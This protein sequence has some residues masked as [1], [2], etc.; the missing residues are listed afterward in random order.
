MWGGGWGS[1]IGVCMQNGVNCPASAAD[2]LATVVS[3]GNVANGSI[4][5]N[6]GYVYAYANA[7]PIRLG[8]LWGHTGLWNGSASHVMYFGSDQYFQFLNRSGSYGPGVYAA[9]YYSSTAGVWMSQLR[10]FDVWQNSHYSGSNGVE[11]AT[12]F[13]DSNN[14]AYY[15]DPDGTSVM[16]AI[17]AN[18]FNYSSDERLKKD[19]QPVASA[20]DKVRQLTGVS[21]TWKETN[22]D[23]IGFIAQEVEKVFPEIVSTDTATGLK[24]VSYGTLTAPLV[25]SVKELDDKS[26]YQ[27]QRIANLENQVKELREEINKLKK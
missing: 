20:L 25:E 14:G 5:I 24:S 2:T 15:V 12:T 8:E 22:A 10:R 26:Q 27:Q 11:Y 7:Y 18:Q 13:Y 1:W 3:R 6:D 21:F 4:V 9:D 17:T 19:I 16:N 23:S